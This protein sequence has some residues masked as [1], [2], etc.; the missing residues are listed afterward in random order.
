[1]ARFPKAIL[2]SKSSPPDFRL[3]AHGSDI[4]LRTFRAKNASP[5]EIIDIAGL[6]KSRPKTV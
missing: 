6:K 2:T 5:L 1:M 4:D 3:Y